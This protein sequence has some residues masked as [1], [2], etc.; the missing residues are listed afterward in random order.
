MWYIYIGYNTYAYL[1]FLPESSVFCGAFLW[2]ALLNYDTLDS[3]T[4]ELVDE[5]MKGYKDPKDG[6]TP[7]TNTPLGSN[8]ASRKRRFT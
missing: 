4:K 3:E 2:Q 6:P 8:L 1:F 5:R 7:N